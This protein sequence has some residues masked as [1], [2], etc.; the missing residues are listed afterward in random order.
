[1]SQPGPTERHAPRPLDA[2]H[3]GCPY[4]GLRREPATVY[5]LPTDEHRCYARRKAEPIAPAH[6][7]TTC[8]TDRA[9]ACPR[10]PA[11]CAAGQAPGGATAG[12]AA[13]TPIAP[14]SR[15]LTSEDASQPR[16][17]VERKGARGIRLTLGL[18]AIVLLIIVLPVALAGVSRGPQPLPVTSEPLPTV[19]PTVAPSLSSV[20]SG[21]AAIAAS[22]AQPSAPPAADEAAPD[23]P[24]ATGG[25]GPATA[26]NKGTP[27]VEVTAPP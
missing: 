16:A 8:L 22:A 5:A 20:A 18:A 11:A 17:V 25:D 14:P 4:L 9:I 6:Q 13:T 27:E 24:P 3:Q 21:R 10:Y 26:E 19:S 1:M 2:A 12:V 15:M 23:N 7:A